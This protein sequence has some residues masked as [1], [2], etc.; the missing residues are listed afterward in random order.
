MTSLRV[1]IKGSEWA[2]DLPF[3]TMLAPILL[4]LLHSFGSN[5][6]VSVLLLNHIPVTGYS[7]VLFFQSGKLLPQMCVYI[8]VFVILWYIYNKKYIFGFP[9]GSGT[10]VWSSWDL[11]SEESA[12]GVLCYV[13]EVTFGSLL[14]MGAG[15]QWNQPLGLEGWNFQS[16]TPSSA[17][18]P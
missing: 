2:T 18:T 4:S 14:R 16:H 11:L 10:S 6:A 3:P 5:H 9:L 8:Y 1:K 7:H 13:S 12:K 15:C 17:P